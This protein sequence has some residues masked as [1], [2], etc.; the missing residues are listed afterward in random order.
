MTAVTRL[1]DAILH[2]LI[3]INNSI[4]LSL[5]SPLP[6]C[7]IYT[8]SPRTLSPISTL[9][10]KKKL[11][12]VRVKRPATCVWKFHT[13]HVSKLLNFFVTTLPRSMPSRSTILCA[14][15][16][17][18]VPLNILILGILASKN[19]DGFA[20]LFTWAKHSVSSMKHGVARGIPKTSR[21]PIRIAQARTTWP[22]Y[23]MALTFNNYQPNNLP[24]KQPRIASHQNNAIRTKQ[25]NNKIYLHIRHVLL[26]ITDIFQNIFIN[27]S[28]LLFSYL[29]YM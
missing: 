7:T 5:T 3:I 13:Y 17:W 29:V 19:F 23:H 4:R 6:D 1:A 15:S 8:S 20:M 26:F 14:K 10:W 11:K 16:G 2:A 21:W 12:I 22:T 9:R 28:Y 25:K 18:D 24:R 27:E